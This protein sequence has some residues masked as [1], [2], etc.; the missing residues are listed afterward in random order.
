MAANGRRA[1]PA[2]PI[3]YQTWF[4]EAAGALE[5]YSSFWSDVEVTGMY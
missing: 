1:S 5:A 2:R 4:E 3:A